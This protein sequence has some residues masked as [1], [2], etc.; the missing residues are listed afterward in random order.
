MKIIHMITGLGNGGAENMLYK[1]LSKIDKNE[2]EIEVISMMDKGIIGP[3]IENLGI[4]VHTL[5][6]K[7]GIPS[8]TAI[9]KVMKILNN[10]DVLQT[11]MYHA[12]LLGFIC[13]KLSGVKQ[14]I[15]GIRHNNLD[16]NRNKRLLMIIAN[17]NKKLSKN[18]D[19]IVSCSKDATKVHIEFGYDKSKFITIPNGFD[20]VNYYNYPNSKFELGKEL[21]LNFEGK[22]IVSHVARWDILKDYPTLIKCIR[23]VVNENKNTIFL[24][25]GKNINNNNKDLVNLIDENNISR[26]VY[27]L[28]S[29]SDIPKIMSASDVF[30]L[31]SIGEG[32]PNVLGEAMACET[33]CVV[34]DAGDS[35]YVVGELGKVVNIGDYKGLAKEILYML[36]LPKNELEDLGKKCREKIINEF[37]LN[38]VVKMYESL[39][40]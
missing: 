36:D 17:I 29:R 40:L 26:N 12:D 10:V 20:I 11:W 7:R 30:V 37:E 22:N 35:R 9:K 39:Y 1:L 21:N 25:C 5:N 13:G 23:E 3:K 34:T 27:L 14:I 2:Y 4:K 33:P 16:K 19:K 32:F 24:L 31:S 8:I 6:M 28:G 38:K 15:W 18:V